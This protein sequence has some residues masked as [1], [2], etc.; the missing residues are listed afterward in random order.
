MYCEKIVRFV[1]CGFIFVAVTVAFIGCT[2]STEEKQ[3]AKTALKFADYL[4]NY[5]LKEAA[6][7]ATGDSQ[8]WISFL[9]SNVDEATINL[10]RSQQEDATVSV[11]DVTISTSTIATAT[12]TVSNFVWNS[13]AEGEPSVEK[14][15]RF[16]LHLRK[17]KGEWRVRMD[18]LPQNEK[19]NHD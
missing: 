13:G 18:S 2:E 6:S 11:D 14:E 8:G 7:L 3:V 9:A 1:I 17:E 12:I 15:A 5:E 19:Q 16:T 10:I 4:F